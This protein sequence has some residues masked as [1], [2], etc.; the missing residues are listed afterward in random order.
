MSAG[1]PRLI[2]QYDN[3]LYISA[4][5][6]FTR[7]RFVD[8]GLPAGTPVVL[9]FRYTYDADAEV[10]EWKELPCGV[11]KTTIDAEGMA[12]IVLLFGPPLSDPARQGD[13]FR[14]V[15][16]RSE[17]PTVAKDVLPRLAYSLEGSDKVLIKG[18]LKLHSNWR[19]MMRE[20]NLELY[21][22]I[23]SFEEGGVVPAQDLYAHLERK[24]TELFVGVADIPVFTFELF[25]ELRNAAGCDTNSALVPTDKFFG[26]AGTESLLYIFHAFA[27]LMGRSGIVRGLY[28]FKKFTLAS[29]S[30]DIVF[31]GK[32]PKRTTRRFIFRLARTPT[33]E[34]AIVI[35]ILTIDPQGKIVTA[36]PA[37]YVTSSRLTSAYGD[38][39][40][41][42]A[43]LTDSIHLDVL[44][45]LK[46]KHMLS[47]TREGKKLHLSDSH[48]M[49]I[50]HR[51][52]HNDKRW[53]ASNSLLEK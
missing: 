52:T 29:R 45:A 36:T 11:G 26:N 47:A 13:A 38:P 39:L 4:A 17:K 24:W 30:D 18:V 7:L 40:I 14:I 34:P 3:N 6:R 19:A 28:Y 51:A 10:P 46:Y 49:Q 12:T 41:A 31:V 8:L 37:P 21:R 35:E 48:E 50:M 42:F 22:K 5:S 43:Q 9:S 23:A 44:R 25:N 32:Q 53:W 33:F 1:T 2:T 16:P 15:L 20:L 27:D